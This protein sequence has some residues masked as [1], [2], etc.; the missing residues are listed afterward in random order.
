MKIIIIRAGAL[1]D[2]LMLMPS[3]VQ[4]RGKAEIILVARSPGLELISPY[5]HL[6]M[7]YERT[8]WHQL[9]MDAPE[10][11]HRLPVPRVDMVV[12]FLR[13][14]EGKVH[15]NLKALLRSGSFHLFSPFPPGDEITHIAYHMAQSLRESGLALD[16][17]KAIEE[18]SR[19]AIFHTGSPLSDEQKGIVI[20]PGSGSKNKNHPPDFWITLIGRLMG[21]GL[22]HKKQKG[23][24]LLGPAEEEVA[25]Y[26]REKIRPKVVEIRV[27][28]DKETLLRTLKG[29]LLYIGHDS[30]ITHLSAMLGTPLIALFKGSSVHHWRPLGPAVRVIERKEADLTLMGE[31]METAKVLVKTTHGQIA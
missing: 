28:P 3:I 2:T 23:T 4:L 13:D 11:L 20:H 12:A 22:I 21:E 8:G 17:K 5:V 6:C 10:N 29:A 31:V 9:F 25:P 1:G 26:F 15:K 24:L 14:Q 7:D 16:P 18:T 30:G 19:R 27:T